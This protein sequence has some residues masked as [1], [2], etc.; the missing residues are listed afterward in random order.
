M[1]YELIVQE[2]FTERLAAGGVRVRQ[3]GE[4]ITDAE[5]VA[6]LGGGTEGRHPR[7]VQVWVDDPPP[8]PEAPATQSAPVPAAVAAKTASAPV[9][10]AS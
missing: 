1:P 9:V 4:H 3:A 6:A 7:V 5:E 2:A 8:Q 10:P